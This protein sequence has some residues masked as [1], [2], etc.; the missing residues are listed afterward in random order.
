LAIPRE[1]AASSALPRSREAIAVTSHNSPFCIPGIT[2][3]KPILAAPRTPHR[4]LFAMPDMIAANRLFRVAPAS[5]RLSGGRLA[6]RAIISNPAPPYRITETMGCAGHPPDSRQDAR[7]TLRTLRKLCGL[8]GY[9]LKKIGLA[10]FV[11]YAYACRFKLLH[12]T[13]S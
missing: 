12:A 11:G 4:T 5:R 6:L 10:K 2:F 8:C 3:F 13:R 7:A 9:A 1:R